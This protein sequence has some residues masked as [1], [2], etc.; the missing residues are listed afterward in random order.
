MKS[1]EFWTTN[2]A[3]MFSEKVNKEIHDSLEKQIISIYRKLKSGKHTVNGKFEFN[4]SDY[5]AW[6]ENLITVEDK[7]SIK[8]DAICLKDQ[9]CNFIII[10]KE[11]TKNL[12]HFVAFRFYDKISKNKYE[13]I[14]ENKFD[15][16]YFMSHDLFSGYQSAIHLLE[17]KSS[18]ESKEFTKDLRI[19]MKAKG[20][21]D[22]EIEETLNA[23][24]MLNAN[25]E[26]GICDLKGFNSL[27]TDIELTQYALKAK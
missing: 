16:K 12:H 21:A 15:L 14:L 19:Q 13:N 7:V 26:T 9:N 5:F 23:S 2:V 6:I 8:M 18:P 27:I 22:N 20:F 25:N 3:R 24:H 17:I 1:Y 10:I 4:D 11:L